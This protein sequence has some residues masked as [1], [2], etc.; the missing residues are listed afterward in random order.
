[1]P[2]IDGGESDSESERSGASIAMANASVEVKHAAKFVTTS[3]TE[4]GFALAMER[5]VLGARAVNQA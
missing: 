2:L 5:F 1:M 3:D 4:E